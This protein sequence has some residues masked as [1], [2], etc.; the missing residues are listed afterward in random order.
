MSRRSGPHP[1][2]AHLATLWASAAQCGVAAQALPEIGDLWHPRVRERARALAATLAADDAARDFAAKTQQRLVARLEEVHRGLRAYQAHPYVRTLVEPPVMARAGAARLLD[3]AGP[4]RN[5]QG[6]PVVFVPSLVNP[7]TVLDLNEERSLLRWLARQGAHVLLVDWGEPGA[8]EAGF[9]LDDYAAR[10]LPA[11]IE[12][13]GEPVILAGYCLGGLLAV[14]TAVLH[15]ERVKGLAL[16]AVPWDF[17]GYPDQARAGL[18]GL[19]RNWAAAS[20]ALGAMPMEA[21]QLAFAA[22]DPTLME[23]KFSAFARLDPLSDEAARFVALEDWANSGP[24]LV[25]SAA[26]QAFERFF[27]ANDSG[28]GRWRIGDT[29]IL[30]QHLKLPALAILSANDRLV[31]YPAAA[32]L[33]RAI[34]G[35]TAITVDAGHVGMVVGSRARELLWEPLARWLQAR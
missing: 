29:P 5:G 26:H 1:L 2:A 33:A 19:W 18:H 4:H 32:P 13:L 14:A 23:R 24:P 16:L 12:A 9:S 27:M 17:A 3:Y 28:E 8:A 22:L 34:A 11:L 35:C 15:P 10:H 20:Q 25:A 21:L 6:A 30:P 7:A 31:P